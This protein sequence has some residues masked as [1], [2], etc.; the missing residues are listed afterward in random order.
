MRNGIVKLICLGLTSMLL[1]SNDLLGQSDA[2][3]LQNPVKA[4]Q[5][6]P[7]QP[8]KPLPPAPMMIRIDAT[9][10]ELDE[11]RGVDFDF[12]GGNVKRLQ[13]SAGAI[14]VISE[15][16]KDQLTTSLLASNSGR[17]LSQPTLITVNEQEATVQVGG[18]VPVSDG[19]GYAV[20]KSVGLTLNCRPTLSESSI[21]LDIG[22]EYANLDDAGQYR[23]QDLQTTVEVEGG[24]TLMLSGLGDNTLLVLLTP[25]LVSGGSMVGSPRPAKSVV[26]QV[27]PS[28]VRRLTPARYQR[29]DAAT[30]AAV[31][32]SPLKP[33][34]ATIEQAMKRLFPGE[35]I[36]VVTL[37]NSVVLRGRVQKAS[38]DRIISI[39]EQYSPTVINHLDVMIHDPV[40]ISTDH[41]PQLDRQIMGLRDEVRKLRNDIQQL[42]EMLSATK[43]TQ[44]SSARYQSSGVSRA[45]VAT[46]TFNPTITLD[47]I[48]KLDSTNPEPW[49]LSL[50]EAT[51]IM[52]ESLDGLEGD[53]VERRVQ[54]L[55]SNYAELQALQAQLAAIV[56]DKK[57]ADILAK[58]YE[59][60]GSTGGTLNLPIGE[61]KALSDFRRT[62]FRMRRSE[63]SLREKMGL[64]HSDGRLITPAQYDPVRR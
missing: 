56:R 24:D 58:A 30:V 38:M 20:M 60:A 52:K 27:D 25:E 62:D 40:R 64:E 7:S 5:S 26:K 6:R 21:K 55:A 19:T 48:S 8:P 53:E 46:V 54:S 1:P 15:A 3:V 18:Q 16:S 57:P 37:P 2:K 47:S 4:A 32:A 10:V 12:E 14:A 11:K 31:Q 43:K 61:R 42:K 35:Q 63:Q 13:T 22:C 59:S 17:I 49:R 34:L 50:D 45:G 41:G 33:T 29:Q 51:E 44:S 9:V 36:E 23:K 28:A 39:A